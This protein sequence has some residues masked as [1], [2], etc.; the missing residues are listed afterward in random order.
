MR[1]RNIYIYSIGICVLAKCLTW[2]NE[3]GSA[4]KFKSL[5]VGQPSGTASYPP[6]HPRMF[7]CVSVSF[8]MPTTGE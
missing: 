6:H 2:A 1:S 7:V 4:N 8:A 5:Y 3:V